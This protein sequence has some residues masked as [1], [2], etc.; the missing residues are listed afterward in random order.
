MS[1]P[2]DPLSAQEEKSY[3]ILRRIVNII[4]VIVFTT[5]FAF[6]GYE[7]YTFRVSSL[8]IGSHLRIQAGDEKS[9]FYTCDTEPE[10]VIHYRGI[11]S[12]SITALIDKNELDLKRQGLWGTL[13]AKLSK[14]KN[15]KHTITVIAGPYR[16]TWAFS[17]DTE[18]PSIDL[19]GPK[20]GLTTNKNSVTF[21]GKTKPFSRL[22]IKI[23]E[24]TVQ[25][26]IPEDGN[27][28]CVLSIGHGLNTIKWAVTDRAGNSINGERQ[29]ICDLTPPVIEPLISSL[30]GSEQASPKK[31]GT[32]FSERNLVLNLTVKDLDSGIKSTSYVL[33][34]KKPQHLEVPASKEAQEEE[35]EAEAQQNADS[36]PEPQNLE[37]TP[38]DAIPE[39]AA[40]SIDGASF[41]QTQGEPS[42]ISETMPDDPADT[43]NPASEVNNAPIGTR[44][45]ENQAT[46]TMEDQPA[47]SPIA[48]QPS[49]TPTHQPLTKTTVKA[50]AVKGKPLIPG[51]KGRST[52]YTIPLNKLYDGEHSLSVTSVNGMGIANK[53][54]VKF[55]VN[56]SDKFGEATLYLGATGEDVEEL[57]KRLAQRGY[58]EGTYS[59]GLYDEATK[60][61]VIA[62]QRHIGVAQDGVC[63]PMVYG[64]IDKR[65]YVNLSQYEVK[66]ITEDEKIYTY[67]ICIGVE[68]HPTPTGWFYIADMVKDPTWLPPN[69][70]W[71]KD[72]KVIE[73][74]PD[75]PLGTR[76]IGLDIGSIGFHGTPYP[77]TVGTRASHG[78]MRMRLVDIEDL[79]DRVSIGTQVRIFAGDESDNMLHTYWH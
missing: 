56:S 9:A 49:P 5:L 1:A 48:P 34:G 20:D 30:D 31:T 16:E 43:N 7:F 70:E 47:A 58:L 54:I 39:D 59:E 65:L 61:A 29:V 60:E 4:A 64:A 32:I 45:D 67:P 76:W 52:Q 42:E 13:T 28:K 55:N 75:N 26:D 63:G 73:P 8:D 40:T 10:V 36:S 23:N 27:F 22:S 62:L 3:R 37:S 33:D 35:E 6:I 15:G 38:L 50:L 25:N 68:E 12:K 2:L 41:V 11:P 78:C 57:Q 14:L 77:D 51:A 53:R 74:G 66:L 72:A 19:L 24:Q 21:Y 17:V 71:A 18:V 79:Y 69:S 44:D 46:A